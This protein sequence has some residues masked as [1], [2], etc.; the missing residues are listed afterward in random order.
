MIS[1]GYPYHFHS[2]SQDVVEASPFPSAPIDRFTAFM[3]FI[4]NKMKE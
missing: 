1:E 4:R 3:E 2:G